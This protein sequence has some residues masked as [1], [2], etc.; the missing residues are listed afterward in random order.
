MALVQYYIKGL[1]TNRNLWF[2]SVAFMLFWLVLGGYAFSQGVPRT[3]DALIPYTSSWYGIIVTYS[4]SSLAISIAFTIYYASSSLTYCFRYT[5]LTP[6]SYVSTLVGSSSVLGVMLSVIMLA[7]TYGLFSYRFGISLTPSDPLGS[8]VVSAIGGVFMMTLSMLLVLIVV[9]YVGLQSI[10][11]VTFVPLILSFGLGFTQ[12]FTSLP[13]ALVYASPFNDIQSLLYHA[14][15]GT[16]T[17]IQLSDPTS[18]PLQW[19]YLL[20]SLIGWIV[21]LILVDSFLLRR[22]KPRQV[23]EGRQ[24]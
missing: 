5:R 16:A 8:V 7:A 11:L 3:T 18:A 1:L 24:I 2:W 22:L 21:F 20:V 14:Y 13:A 12:L 23:E 15:S 4:L 17:P 6:I 19:E 9:N 10:E